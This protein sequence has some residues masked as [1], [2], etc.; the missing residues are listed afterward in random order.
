MKNNRIL[1]TLLCLV[2]FSGIF[3]QVPGDTIRVKAFEY[4]SESRDTLV[5]FPANGV[6]TYEKILLKYSMRC[7]DAQV[8]TGNNNQAGCRD[9]DFSCNTYI[10][11]S[12]KVESVS[13]TILSHTITNFETANFPFKTTPVY[14]FL[15]ST[16]TNV[17]ITNTI[18]ET[19]AT[20]GVGTIN[21][22]LVLR[23]EN[24]ANKSQYIYSA[25]ELLAAGLVAGDINSLSL[26]V[27]ANAGTANF[28][29]I[30]IK[31][32]TAIA[33]DEQLELD[34]FSE[35]YQ[36]NTVFN[37]NAINRFNFHT[38]FNWDGASNLLVQFN[39]TNLGSVGSTGSEVEVEE[40][41]LPVG[42][43]SV[44]ENS[45]LFG[46]E[47]YVQVDD[48]T[49]VLGDQ[50]RTLEAWIRTVEDGEIMSY[51]VNTTGNRFTWR[52]DQGRL[53][54]EIQGG[55]ILSTAT[56]NDGEWHH[57]ACV[58][59]GNTLNDVSFYI[60][61]VLDPN[62]NN[63]TAVV[64]TTEFPIRIGRGVPGFARF[65]VGTID[66][67]RMWDTNLSG[68][69][70]ND[71]K[72]RKIDATHPNAGNLQL[73]YDF[74]ETGTTILDSSGNGRNATIVDGEHRVSTLDGANLFKDFILSNQRPNVIFYQGNYNTTITTTTEDQPVVK[75]PQ[76]FVVE[77]SIQSE[78]P[79]LPISDTILTAAA[80]ELWSLDQTIFDAET[81]TII[82]TTNLPQDG[83]IIITDLDFISRFPFF[84][85]ILSFVTPFGIGVDFGVDGV[86][87]YFDMTDYVTILNDD[88]RI[89]ITLGGQFQEEL[90]LEFLFIVGTPPR[91]VLQYEQ[92]WQGTNRLGGNPGV[93]VNRIL[94]QS[95]FAATDIPLIAGADSFKLRSS[96]T[97]HGS[98][99]EF[100][101]NGGLVSHRIAVDGT[102]IFDWDIFQECSFNPIFPQGGTW[103]FDRAGWCPGQSSLVTEQDLTPFVTAGQLTTIDYDTS[104]PNNSAGDYRYHAAHQVLG[105]GPANFNQDASVLEIMAP[106]NTAEF[107]RVGTICDDPIIKIRNS[108]ATPLTSLT[109]NYWLNEADTPQVFEWTGNLAFLEEEDVVIPSA[110]ELWFDVL[111]DNNQFFVEILNP[112]GGADEYEFNNMYTSRFDVADII[113]SSFT[114]ET[115]TNNRAFENSYELFDSEGTIVG[116]NNLPDSNTTYQDE[117]DLPEGCYT[118]VFTDTAGDGLQWFANPGQGVGVARIRDTEGT[119]INQFE[120][121]FGGGFTYSFTTDGILSAET[122]DFLT[123]IQ[124]YPNP[125]AT[126]TTLAANDLTD[127]RVHLIDVAGRRIAAIVSSRSV[128]EITLNIQSLSTGAYFVVI[129]KGGVS[130]SRK[131]LKQ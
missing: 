107:R 68:E 106:N 104:I 22:D 5:S 66:E 18:S 38:P 72:H 89:L 61:G 70:I 51:G 99:G 103:V 6:N 91:D 67:V 47:S 11:D 125:A 62:S 87:W 65:F 30:Q 32:T 77:R 42:M 118:L 83:E 82:S 128:Q 50:N 16:Q 131:L 31:H 58:L 26:N 71:W 41:T 100:P 126:T 12:T 121:D 129:E 24:L 10:T 75:E 74:S 92:L 3:A 37:A 48:Y 20:V 94:D 105:Y 78:D 73:Y 2:T 27:L 21:S 122:F 111:A 9:F 56:V 25:S 44:N 14:D 79:S 97:G 36:Q 69:A 15:R 40:L 59:N 116:S 60:D 84:N 80:V 7:H 95:E 55:N 98:D 8:N 49:G 17:E 35:V 81:G 112:N 102:E 29:D 63:N 46:S 93:N 109:I 57:V 52:I 13:S 39:F 130:T 53:R 19:A 85:E 64:N 117:Y 34:G 54:A 88:K 23:T 120:N 101:Q 127:A 76:H 124:L 110:P 1:I 114:F 4:S 45:L 123:S 43:N 90:D 28:L 96:I 86:S 33:L 108:G 115:V 119:I 113:T